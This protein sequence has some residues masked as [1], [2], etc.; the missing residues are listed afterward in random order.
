MIYRSLVSIVPLPRKR[1][2]KEWVVLLSLL[3]S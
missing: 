1:R 2:G 3:L